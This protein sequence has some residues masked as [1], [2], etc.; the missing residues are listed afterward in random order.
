MPSPLRASEHAHEDW[1]PCGDG[2]V[3]LSH[4]HCRL[5]QRSRTNPHITIFL[6]DIHRA[7]TS[8]REE[9]FFRPW[10]ALWRD[11]SSTYTA[12]WA[13]LLTLRLLSAVTEH[14]THYITSTPDLFSNTLPCILRSATNRLGMPTTLTLH[15]ENTRSVSYLG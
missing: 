2:I 11:V 7:L 10:K 4:V 6:S 8:S 5:Y 12:H 14:L 1:P 15:H 9:S 3:T 13:N